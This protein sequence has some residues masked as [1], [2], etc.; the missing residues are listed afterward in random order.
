LH[1]REEGVGALDVRQVAC[2]S[3]TWNV[4]RGS[5]L[6]RFHEF[7]GATPPESPKTGTVLA[8]SRG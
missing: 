3:M 4:E 5:A 6:C 1:G 8:C 2:R 7:D